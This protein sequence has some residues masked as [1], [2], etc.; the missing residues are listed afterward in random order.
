ML[1]VM[2]F[3]TAQSWGPRF[4]FEILLEFCAGAYFPIDVLP[5]A[6]QKILMTLPFPY[7]VFF[8]PSSIYLGR[9]QGGAIVSCL[10]HQVFWIVALSFGDMVVVRIQAD[11]NDGDIVV[12]RL[13]D[14]A[15]VKRLRRKSHKTFLEPANYVIPISSRNSNWSAWWWKF[16]GITNEDE[17][18]KLMW[19]ALPVVELSDLISPDPVD[20]GLYVARHEDVSPT[21]VMSHLVSLLAFESR[22]A[23]NTSEPRA[24]RLRYRRSAPGGVAAHRKN[25]LDGYQPFV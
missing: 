5:K 14:E 4:C 22:E 12:A 19:S 24:S 11:A 18:R 17:R 7:L 23:D 2:G 9:I 1:G 21:H 15:T 16:D 3:W 13:I 20:R 8:V 25:D 6:A 10:L